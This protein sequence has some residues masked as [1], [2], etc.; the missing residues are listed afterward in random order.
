MHS[1]INR[2]FKVLYLGSGLFVFTVFTIKFVAAICDR[3]AILTEPDPRFDEFK[4]SA[5]F[6]NDEK[7]TVCFFIFC[8]FILLQIVVAST[9]YVLNKEFKIPRSFL[10][11][12]E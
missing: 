6:T 9:N 10:T 8:A 1:S 4:Q 7:L 12:K 2:L 5:L 3:I 11:F